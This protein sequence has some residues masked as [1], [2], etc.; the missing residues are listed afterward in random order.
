MRVIARS[1]QAWP[2]TAD[3]ADEEL[4][5]RVRR[6]DQR[7]FEAIYQRYREPLYRYCHSILRQREDAEEAFQATMLSAFQALSGGDQRAIALRPWLYRIAHN[8]CISAL[9]KRPRQSAAELTGREAA[10]VDVG[11]TTELAEDLRQLQRDM[12]ELPEAQRAALV[13]RELGGLSH[14]EIGRVLDEDPSAV[15]QLIYGARSALHDL[16]AGRDLACASVRRTLSDGDGR[17]LRGRGLRAH[18]RSCAGCRTWQADLHA[19]PIRLAALAP[20]ISAAAFAHI[21]EAVTGAAAAAGLGAGIAAAT[22]GAGAAGGAAAAGAGAAGGAAAGGSALAAAGGA[23]AGAGAAA[24]GGLAVKL[25][26]IGSATLIGG[27]TAVVPAVESAHRAPPPQARAHVVQASAAAPASIV[28]T[29]APPAAAAAAGAPGLDRAAAAR[30][31]ARE[32]AIARVADRTGE[33]RG[34]EGDAGLDEGRDRGRGLASGFRSTGSGAG[35]ARQDA[36]DRASRAGLVRPDGLTRRERLAGSVDRAGR[37]RDAALRD[38]RTGSGDQLIPGT[39]ALPL[40]PQAGEGEGGRLGIRE[41]VRNRRDGT[42]TPT[43]PS[44]P[45]MAEPTTP[46]VP[47]VPAL[48]GAPTAPDQPSAEDGTRHAADDPAG[49]TNPF[50]GR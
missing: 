49:Y 47:I 19:R 1:Q 8:T 3:V 10:A 15:K 28:F 30:R 35:A 2:L 5:R 26:A 31:E 40:A 46:L 37:A 41:R 48:P 27:G 24:S 23:G 29:A 20:V 36:N 16:A 13:M 45:G 25:A 22:A 42:P 17:S 39:I 38:G 50:R 12:A 34:R 32:R 14:V 6:R 33:R 18:L 21:Y 43:A 4:V 9:R 7:A 44:G 11:A